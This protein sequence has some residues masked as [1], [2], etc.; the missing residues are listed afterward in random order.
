MALPCIAT[1]SDTAPDLQVRFATTVKH[2]LQPI[3]ESA[4]RNPVTGEFEWQDEQGLTHVRYV[5]P[6]DGSQ[7]EFVLHPTDNAIEIFWDGRVFI[8]DIPRVLLGT[9]FGRWLRAQDV[10]AL[11]ANVV[12]IAGAAV[13][14]CGG[15]G[16]GKSTTTAALLAAGH[17]LLTDDLAA[18]DLSG[19]SPKVR[20]GYPHLRLWPDSASGLGPEWQNLPLVFRNTETMGVKVYRDLAGHP[21]LFSDTDLPLSCVYVLDGRNEGLE[22]TQ[23]ERLPTGLAVPYLLRNL[24]LGQGRSSQLLAA[25]LPDM[26]H[27]AERCPVFLVRV[28]AGLNRLPELA[29][30]MT[31]HARTVGNRQD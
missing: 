7:L 9:I 17:P 28:A 10:T 6:L 5:D 15:S 22:Q 16:S 29:A 30:A 3:L 31:A 14:V 20:H 25:Y 26:V 11:H 23:F 4:V 12:N 27:V 21:E 1:K 24:Y 19:S 18:L 2:P 8:E 13:L